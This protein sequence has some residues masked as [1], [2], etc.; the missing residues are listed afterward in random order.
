VAAVTFKEQPRAITEAG[1]LLP[2]ATLSITAP[3]TTDARHPYADSELTTSLRDPLTA[4]G[5]GRFPAI[6][7][8]DEL[9]YR[10][11]LFHPTTGA[12]VWDQDPLETFPLTDNGIPLDNDGQPMPFAVLTFW[13]GATTQLEPIYEDDT[14]TGEL[15]NPI[16]ADSA[17]EFPTIYLD[18]D[19][20]YRVRLVDGQGRLVYDVDYYRTQPQPE[21]PFV[22]PGA[23][24]LSGEMV[25]LGDNVFR[26]ELEWTA[27]TPGSLPVDHY[28]LYRSEDGGGF[29][30]LDSITSPREFIDTDIETDVLYSYYVVAIDQATNPGPD[31]NVLELVANESVFPAVGWINPG[32]E[33]SDTVPTG[34]TN[35]GGSNLIVMHNERFPPVGSNIFRGNMSVSS[36]MYQRLDLVGIGVPTLQIDAANTR[37]KIDWWGGTFIQ[38]P[39]DQ[40]AINWRF[41]D[42]S[43]AQISSGTSGY[44]NPVTQY[45][46]NIRWDQYQESAN[47]PATCRY[48]D[49]EMEAKRNNGSNNDAAFDEVVPFVELIA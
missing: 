2:G 21:P 13:R 45:G 4:D 47:I 9:F 22:A 11:R 42:G 17:G 43:L 20:K 1:A 48:I 40:P 24:V 49:I 32:A 27:A 6:Y 7:F 41:L 23:A 15:A 36:K 35:S 34:W 14:L 44:K 10:A 46:T 5:A 18:E 26:A 19:V 25:D 28:D 31:S 8:D 30:L 3:G 29:S 37:L 33:L 38:T 16:T 12:L 39:A